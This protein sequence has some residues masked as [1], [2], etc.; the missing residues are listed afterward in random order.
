MVNGASSANVTRSEY[1]TSTN[2]TERLL[3]AWL[4]AST[5]IRNDRFVKELTY[6]E[7]IICKLLAE[8]AAAGGEGLTATDLCSATQMKKSQMNRTLTSMEERGLVARSISKEDHR[9]QLVKI[10]PSQMNRFLKQHERIIAFVE[11]VMKELGSTRS[12]ELTSALKDLAC[13]VRKVNS[14]AV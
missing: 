9:K 14:G 6:N 3:D 10:E 7:S 12:V 8:D 1:N 11:S 4:Q 2:A 13:A 5:A